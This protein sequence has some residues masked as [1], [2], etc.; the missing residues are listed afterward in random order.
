MTDWPVHAHIDGPIVM[1]GFGSIGKGTLPLIERHFTYDK[2]RFVVID[3]DDADCKILD[4]RGIRFIHQAVT[5]ENFRDLLVPLLT[6][7]SGRGFCVNLSVDTSS[8]AIMELAREVGAFYI[9]TVT[10]PWPG[11]YFD[12]KLDPAA[13]SNYA[14]RETL[15]AARRRRPGGITAVSCCGANPGMVSWFV[16][17]A[18]IDIARDLNV[19]GDLGVAAEAPA[20]RADWGRLAMR[21]GV[22]G[23]H[24]AERDTQRARNPKP[25]DVFV[26]TWSVEGFLSEGMQPAELGWGTHE[27]WMPANGRAHETG[28]GA[29]IYLSQPGA[30]TRVRS[31]TPTPQAQY[32][33]LVTHNESISI[34]DYFTLRDGDGSDESGKVIYRPTCHYAYHPCNDAVLS[35]HELFGRAGVMQDTHH[36]LDEHEIVDGIDE[37]GVLIYGHAKNAYWYGSQLSVEETRVLAPYQNATGLQV[38]SAVLAGMVWALENPERGIVE[39]DEMD[40]FRCLEIQRPYLG[41]VIGTYTD[42]TP[43]KDR[44][45]LFPENIDLSDPWQFRN[46]LVGA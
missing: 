44:P 40:S 7:G 3:P 16:K 20:T 2:D 8:V 1:I 34:A 41:P 6:A 33:F 39:A 32:G 19:A 24:I 45:G 30:N 25:M 42:W 21:L 9:D 29:A 11:L 4:A 5:R 12:A 28:C 31:W 27:T 36:I 10:E 46:V 17:Q 26:N 22:K 23:I 35:L 37:L 38:T 43:L 15:L 13:R 14:L 18:L